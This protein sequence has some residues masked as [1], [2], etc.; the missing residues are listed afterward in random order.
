MFT[1]PTISA[2]APAYTIEEEL[3]SGVIRMMVEGFF[4]IGTLTRHFADS[5]I[6]VGRWRLLGRPIRVL[7]DAKTLLPHSPEGQALVQKSVQR[8]YA[9][10]D[11]VAILVSSNLVKMQ[12]RRALSQGE[13]VNFFVSDV[14]ATTWLMAYA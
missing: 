13:V 3:V 1:F 5:A 9:P 6:Y 8:I 4:D 7:I 14:A 2:N 10:G 12:M 11:R